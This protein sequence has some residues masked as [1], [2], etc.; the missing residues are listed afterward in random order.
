[1]DTSPFPIVPK[2]TGD[3]ESACESQGASCC[4]S[5][6]LPAS[7]PHERP[8]YRREHFV[9]GFMDTPA[10]P[11]PVV[12]TA[13]DC[14]DH[15]GTMG[16]RLGVNR[17]NY[18]VAPGL[19][20]VGKPDTESPVLVTANYKLSFDS[21]RRELDGLGV[22]ILVLDTRGV[23]VWCAAGKG[24]FSTAEVIHQVQN[25]G[26]E[27]V[28]SHGRLILPQLGATG[29]SALEVKRGCG[30][31]VKWGP[32]RASDLLAF[33]TAGMKAEPAMRRVTFTLA[34]RLVLIPV[35]LSF[36]PKLALWALI[37]AFVLSGI[38]P[39]VFS[40]GAAWHRGWMVAAA[41]A[42]AVAA[43]TVATPALLPWL[44]GSAFAV[45]GSLAGLAA[46][47]VI[48]GLL[49]LP[50]MGLPAAA[51]LLCTTALSS[52]LAMNFTGSTPFTSPSGVE[53]EMRRAIPLQL[54]AIVIAAGT[55]I[56]AAFH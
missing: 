35:E 24:T 41:L 27:R 39:H 26:L 11:V 9:A 30:F 15:W 29:V 23:N 3:S 21:L 7:S 55:W 25:S 45:K 40:P 20:A 16:A 8:G 52:F 46:G 17:D 32:I 48:L 18:P 12:K 22:W 51:L 53:K 50:L 13:L 19:Y 10:G 43:G 49:G 33:L 6:P 44:P 36:M 34:E 42:A 38:G 47:L 56:G 28:V 54:A 4:G 31:E 5:T 14:H 1:M 2:T 37:A